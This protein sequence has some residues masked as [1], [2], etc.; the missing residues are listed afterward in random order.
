MRTNLESP[1]FL[2][3]VAVG[4]QPL[5]YAIPGCSATAAS[6][7]ARPLGRDAS[8]AC[9]HHVNNMSNPPAIARL[10]VIVLLGLG[11]WG[12]SIPR[13]VCQDEAFVG[14]AAPTTPSEIYGQG[15]RETDWQSPA[16]EQAGFHL[17][18]GFSIELFA[19]E[20]LI[21][22]PLN[23]AWDA[24]GR[25][26]VTSS[27]AYPYP[28]ADS[29][30]A[31]DTLK[32]L[33][34]TDGDGRA[35]KATTFADGLNIPIGVLPV[36][37]GAICFSI[38]N[39]WLLRDVDGDDRA[40][41]R[42]KLLGPFDTTRDTHGMINSLTRGDDG[43]V[44]AC[45][46]FNNQSHVTAA[47]GSQVSLTSG[48]TFRF[49]EDGSRV[50][51]VTQGQVNPFGMTRDEW[52]NFYT[53]DCHSKPLTALLPGGCYPSFGRPHDGL[54]FA[55]AMMDH[56]HGSTAIC[57]LNYY[58][59]D[60]FPAAYRHR[61]YS[62]NVM[63][64]RINA[65]ALVWQGATATARELP[66]FLTSDDPWFRPVDIQLG[67]DGSLYVA[68]FYN[69]IIGHYEVPLD[70]PG[71]D[72]TSGR[73]W[74]I[75]YAG[76]PAEPSQV[77]CANVLAELASSNATR[78]E[79]AVELAI[80][81]LQ[82]S[83]AA[84]AELL[85]D[86]R[87]NEDLRCSCL[88]VLYRRQRF[89]LSHAALEPATSPHR[90]LLVQQLVLACDLPAAP[91]SDFA[92]A[93][94]EALPYAAPQAQRAAVRLLGAS[95]Q[96]ADVERLLTLARA[97]EDPA[98]AHTARIALKRVFSD[99]DRLAAAAQQW[100]GTPNEAEIM[101]VLPA[102][103]SE[104]AASLL[105][106]YVAGRRDVPA[107]LVEAAVQLGMQHVNDRLLAQWQQALPR[108]ADGD[109][110][111]QTQR[112]EQLCTAYLSRRAE[113]PDSLRSFGANL[114][115]QVEQALAEQL[116]ATGPSNRWQA[117]EGAAWGWEQRKAADG[118]AVKLR[119]S[120]SLGERYTG[121][122]ISE[123]FPCPAKLRFWLAGHNGPPARPD[124]KRN[125]VQLQLQ[126][127]G[128][129]LQTAYPPRNDVAQAIDWELAEY[130]GQPVRLVVTDAD[131]GTAYAWLAVGR[132][133]LPGL[134]DEREEA[135]LTSY[136]SLLRRGFAPLDRRLLAAYPNSDARHAAMV[137]AS[138]HGSGAATAAG[139]AGW[140]LLLGHAEWVNSA[141]LDAASV[142]NLLPAARQIASSLTGG[143]QPELARQ[144]LRTA[145][146][147]R[148]LQR[149]LTDGQLSPHC[150]QSLEPL[151]P[152]GLEQSTQDFLQA[153]K[154][155]AAAGEV[156][157]A[158][159]AA[160]LAGLDWSRGD[161]QLGQQLFQQ[162]CA[163]CHQL[164]GV[165]TLLGPQ[166]DGA[167]VRG[168]PR[169][170]EDILEPNVNVDHAFR[171]SALLLDDDSV[172]SGLVRE[173]AGGVVVITGGDGRSQQ[174]AASRIVHR[175]DSLQSLMPGNFSE[176]LNDEQ[177][178]GLLAFL[179]QAP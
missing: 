98:L 135:W 128:A 95:P 160:R 151:W 11:L 28:A 155:L 154:Q 153:Q 156:P 40:D 129:T 16:Q 125:H 143:Q 145:D 119:S 9:H 172:V 139:L 30:S 167:V 77:D 85:A 14:A 42:I 12:K 58:R 141:W 78:R 179:A 7:H 96:P 150:L 63:T 18:P 123:P 168:V 117:T 38:P 109:L 83:D 87:Q 84:L 166:L 22:K 148:L 52:G 159:T 173:Q 39:L 33:E 8:P 27:T 13:A 140:A 120:L 64:S 112:L 15:V 171:T 32:I 50:E 158:L 101:R 62:G 126:T 152:S 56:L 20:P 175:R 47:D 53:A 26:W 10:S 81:D 54:G 136:G 89:D 165:G 106:A 161:R 144:L 113:L 163:A 177:L 25:L 111:V 79:L 176:L 65:N 24:R 35:D 21:A 59:A 146:G 97:P 105:L 61:F 131:A 130:A 70:H 2:P 104:Q 4:W 134:N 68:D 133:S 132:F 93:V 169:L 36:A 69:R 92:A 94:R 100:A 45:H 5:A 110:N 51:L 157:G 99:E 122:W 107:S 73:I 48:N 162:H 90:R 31:G 178:R 72:R 49:R 142:D 75:T 67:L 115:H 43:W 82:L 60:Q 29:S 1:S 102:V 71:R 164:R 116:S 34:D 55:P 91:R 88:E 138:L 127:S 80:S 66:D 74:R 57:G 23:M 103:D 108:M 17:P 86:A 46:G 174:I 19:S 114:Q 137:A 170:S 6:C 149:L 76:P 37:Q 147:C 118:A 44:Y 3:R 121:Q 41:E 124:H